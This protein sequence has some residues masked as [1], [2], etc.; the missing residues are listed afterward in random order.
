VRKWEE[1][2]EGNQERLKSL[3]ALLKS[4]AAL[5]DDSEDSD[6]TLSIPLLT[7]R[8]AE[9]DAK[10]SEI[11]KTVELHERTKLIVKIVGEARDLARDRICA[12]ILAECNK[13]LRKV[14]SQDPI[15]L[16]R[17]DSSLH[18]AHQAGASV[19]QTLAVRGN[20]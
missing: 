10:I 14:L 5:G 15:Q 2:L 8:L 18:L 4:I 1:E 19:G 11:T 20:W 13:T 12:L 7:R 9:I 6:K 3:D 16:D 17:I